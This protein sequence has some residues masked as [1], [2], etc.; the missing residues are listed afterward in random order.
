MRASIAL[1]GSFLCGCGAAPEG[2]CFDGRERIHDPPPPSYDI[3]GSDRDGCAFGPDTTT[4]MTVGSDAPAVPDAVKHVIIV[5]HENHSFDQYLGEYV[6]TDR[7]QTNYDPMS[8]VDVAPF[9]ETRYCITD[10]NHEWGA[11]HLAFDNGN[12]DGFVANA[13]DTDGTGGTMLNEGGGSRVMGYY[14]AD[15]LPFYY[16]LAENFAISDHYF[17]SILGPT[18]ANLMFYYR[19]TSC[20]VAEGFDTNPALDACGHAEWPDYGTLASGPS[21]FDRLG[22]GNAKVYTASTRAPVSAAAGL[23]VFDPLKIGT[24]ADFEADVA[25]DR[26]P[27]LAFV[28]PDYGD[29]SSM[30]NDEHPPTNIQLG[31]NLSYRVVSAVIANPAVWGSTIMFLTWDENGGFYDHVKPPHACAPDDVYKPVDFGFDNYGFRVP[32]IAVSPFAKKGYISSYTADHTSLVRFIEHWKHT[33]AMTKRDANAWPLLDMFDFTQTPAAITLDPALGA[34]SA[35]PA[36]IGTC[37]KHG[38]TGMP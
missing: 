29:F 4:D 20:D 27:S 36:H 25:A 12:L 30:E 13:N 1:F 31:Q 11:A 3:K 6:H 28:E 9:H 38:G 18:H 2:N 34:I 23:T 15:D 7:N 21:I 26:L 24:I 32:L 22:G 17:S 8:G 14:T 10:A 19:A 16:W 37:N 33:G 35:D 5:M